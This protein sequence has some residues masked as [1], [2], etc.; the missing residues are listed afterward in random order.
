M[1]DNKIASQSFC[2]I[3]DSLQHD[4]NIVHYFLHIILEDLKTNIR[5]LKRCIYFS[6]GADHGVPAEWHLFSTSHRKRPC[7]GVGGTVKRLVSRTGLQLTTDAID[8]MDTVFHCCKGNIFCIPL[9]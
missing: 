8:T 4:T 6:D 9:E 5:Q 7:D 3:S 2:V 1:K